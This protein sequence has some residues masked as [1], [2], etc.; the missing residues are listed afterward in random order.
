MQ[1][2]FLFELFSVSLAVLPQF[3]AEYHVLQFHALRSL[4]RWL[5]NVGGERAEQPGRLQAELN[6][7]P[8]PGNQNAV[9][10]LHNK[11]QEKMPE[12]NYIL[13]VLLTL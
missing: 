1:N 11:M 4:P 3:L 5:R 2:Y 9:R 8:T 10:L 13:S 12:V 6:T 7:M